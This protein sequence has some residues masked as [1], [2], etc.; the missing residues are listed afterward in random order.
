MGHEAPPVTHLGQQH[1]MPDSPDEALLERVPNPHPDTHYVARFTAPEFT[2]LC[3]VT[4]QPDFAHLVID[5]VPERLAGR[6]S[7]SLKLYLASFR[8]H[9]AFH[10]DCTVAI[11]KRL[12]A[13]ARAALAA[14]RRLLVSA[15]R[16]ADR[17][18]LADAAPARRACGCPTR[19]SRPTAGA[20]DRPGHRAGSSTSHIEH[21]SGGCRPEALWSDACCVE[22]LCQQRGRLLAALVR[23]LEASPMDANGAP[24]GQSRRAWSASAG[25]V[26]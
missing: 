2:S 17:R 24:C 5:Y 23:Q 18:L 6:E 12:V 8:N 10:E 1:Q 22:R 3:P 26:C 4:G 15:R 13:A 11:G 9:G 21:I 14:H 25:S 7:K 20:A 19:A 16:H